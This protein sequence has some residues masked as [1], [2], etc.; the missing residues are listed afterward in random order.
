MTRIFIPE[1]FAIKTELDISEGEP[2][3]IKA[4]S[5]KPETII[6]S[7]ANGENE[8][9]DHIATAKKALTRGNYE[10]FKFELPPCF[11]AKQTI[12][13][14]ITIGNANTGRLVA[15]LA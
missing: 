14:K 8:T 6:F 12:R 10:Y 7:R 3:Y 5:E 4:N 2:V 15:T 11:N 13:K 9:F 1:K